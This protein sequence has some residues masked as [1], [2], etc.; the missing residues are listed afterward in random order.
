MRFSHDEWMVT[1]Y[2]TNPDPSN[3]PDYWMRVDTLLTAQWLRALSL[4]ID[5]VIDEGF[6][7]RSR[8]DHVRS[9]VLAAG[10]TSKL[11]SLSCSESEM[12]ERVR[13][14]NRDLKGSLYID[15]NTFESLK[16]R[17]EPLAEDEEFEAIWT[18]S[19]ATKI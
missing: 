14:R 2:G 3:F 15:D 7:R 19:S 18:G 11:Y 9:L 16:E 17:V 5:V 6:W 1:L 10:A 8:R 13:S 4:G 12:K